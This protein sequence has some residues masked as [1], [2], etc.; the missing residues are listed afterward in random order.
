MAVVALGTAHEWHGLP[1]GPV[2]VLTDLAL[3]AQPVCR[4]GAVGWQIAPVAEAF[5]LGHEAGFCEG[6]RATRAGDD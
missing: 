2:D 1:G 5:R 3:A 4:R 6:A